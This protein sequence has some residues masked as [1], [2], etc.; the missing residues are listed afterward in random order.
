MG[1]VYRAHDTR[2][3]RDV[4]VK[5]MAEHIAADPEMRRRF[6]T[7]ARSVAALSHPVILSIYEL[8]IVDGM[9]VVVTELLHG[10]TLRERLQQGPFAWRDPRPDRAPR[11][12]TAWRPRTRRASSTAISSPRTSSSRAT[13]R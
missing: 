6:E 5:V 9:M 12:P 3:D 13:V 7:E 4:A 2:L 11:S 10:R 1:E 8:A